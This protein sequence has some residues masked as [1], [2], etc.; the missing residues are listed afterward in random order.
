MERSASSVALAGLWY[1]STSINCG[2]GGGGTY[3]FGRRGY[4]NNNNVMILSLAAVMHSSCLMSEWIEQVD[5]FIK[6]ND[7]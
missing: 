6:G 3:I 2:G 7:W 1:T 5:I 4:D